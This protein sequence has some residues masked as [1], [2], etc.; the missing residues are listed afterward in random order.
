V[1]TS[2]I[3][4]AVA[5]QKIEIR[6]VIHVVEICAIGARI[7]FVETDDALRCHEH[8]VYVAIV[9]FVVFAKT[10]S[11]NLFQIETH[12][13]KTSAIRVRNANLCHAPVARQRCSSR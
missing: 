3:K 10:R 8:A 9:Q 5:A 4:N 12:E 2:K 13:N 6:L 11:D 7:D 1:I